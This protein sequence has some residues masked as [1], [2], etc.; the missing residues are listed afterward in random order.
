MGS[1]HAVWHACSVLPS[2]VVPGLVSPFAG[3]VIT[4]DV[5]LDA[6]VRAGEGCRGG[7][8]PVGSQRCVV[9]GGP[10]MA[11]VGAAAVVVE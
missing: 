2:L 7:W 9:V 8:W 3:V 5:C 11:A 6:C 1:R 10:R 4:A